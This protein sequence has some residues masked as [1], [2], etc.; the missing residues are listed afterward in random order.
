[1]VSPTRYVNAG[2]KRTSFQTERVPAHTLPAE[3]HRVG[4]ITGKKQ[5]YTHTNPVLYVDYNT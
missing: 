3:D 2:P 5:Q 4:Y 1:M